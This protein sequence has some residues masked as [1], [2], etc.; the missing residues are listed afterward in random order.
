MDFLYGFYIKTNQGHTDESVAYL[1]TGV[2]RQ[3]PKM[4]MFSE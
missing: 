2:V 1:L 4:S 3:S